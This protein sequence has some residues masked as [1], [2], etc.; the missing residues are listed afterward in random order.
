MI[1]KIR[2]LDDITVNKI[3]A[4]E[5]IENTASVVKELV[6][7]SIDAGASEITV[8]IK[9]GGRQLIRVTDNGCGMHPDDAVLCFERHATSKIRTIDEL[10]AVLS[11]GFRGEA[12]PSIAS[13][14]KFTLHT[15]PEG[16]EEGTL[17]LAEGGKILQSSPAPRAQ[18]TTIEVKALFF[19]VPVRK[20]FQ[21]SPNYDTNEVLKVLS[22]QALAHPEIKF[23]LISNQA[24]L[25][26]AP[27]T[28]A[29]TF[30]EQLKERIASCLGP[31]FAAG[32]TSLESEKGGCG[33][34]GFI[35]LPSFNRN[36]RTGQYLFIN[37]RAV[38][39]PLISHAVKEGY[40]TMIGTN[41]HPVFVLHLRL[42]NGM[43]DVNVHPQKREIRL[44]QQQEV[45]DWIVQSVEKA[46]QNCG[47]APSFAP[48]AFE[49]PPAFVFSQAPVG[50]PQP[51]KETVY[52]PPKTEALTFRETEREIGAPAARTEAPRVVATLPGYILLQGTSGSVRIVDQRAAHSRILYEEL[53]RKESSKG[54][55]PV[56]HLLIPHT[57]ELP[58]AEASRLKEQLEPLG[59]MGI[60]IEEFGPSSFIVRAVPQLLSATDLTQL[61]AEL[62]AALDAPDEGKGPSFDKEKRLAYSAAR[63]AVSG[64][65]TLPQPEAQ[66]LVL[67]LYKCQAPGICPFGRPTTIEIAP[68]D[69]AKLFQGEAIRA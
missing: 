64:K 11:M 57:V 12:I 19:N 58:P 38:F 21:R 52:S 56:Q 53:S 16:K 22:M 41:R 26:M 69:L 37:G 3:A 31:D 7:N 25:M 54:S 68:E 10:A 18:G 48:I 5:V 30:P 45:R 23:Q 40:G 49:R 61:L 17:V 20:K 62:A 46:L 36:N 55:L 43:V 15:C 63:S 66:S 50:L 44:R 24:S 1:A 51:P 8:E 47:I 14:S 35:G 39:S 4:G 67:Q 32:L 59:K 2:V 13:I 33:A 28:T 42:P 29:T 9:G 27:R 34:A 60:Q 65:K 6:E